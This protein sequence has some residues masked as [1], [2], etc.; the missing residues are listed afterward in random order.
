MVAILV[1]LMV[2]TFLTVDYFIQRRARAATSIELSLQPV[3]TAMRVVPAQVPSGIFLDQ[4][5]QWMQLETTGGLKVGVDALASAILGRF[6]QV[7][8]PAIGTEFR[9][10]EAIAKLRKQDRVL[11]LRALVDGRVEEVNGALTREPSMAD[12]DPFGK[13]WIYRMTPRKLNSA[14]LA[15]KRVGEEASAWMRQ[16][17]ARLRDFVAAIPSAY[18]LPGA[19]LQDGGCPVQGFADALNDEQ[20]K[21]LESEFFNVGA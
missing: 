18:A 6:D 15:T 1:L 11:T 2:I 13:G 14:V 20:W 5:H 19:T 10:G 4:S 7:E 3:Q 16:E 9:R 17:M 21:K 12:S 8:L